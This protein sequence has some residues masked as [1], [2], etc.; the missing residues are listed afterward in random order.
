MIRDNI[1]NYYFLFKVDHCIFL[2][3]CRPMFLCNMLYINDMLD[4][5]ALLYRTR[6]IRMRT[7]KSEGT[8]TLCITVKKAFSVVHPWPVICED[9]RFTNT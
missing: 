3:T 5:P 7:S 2:S 8:H 1:E 6:I 9:W 4:P